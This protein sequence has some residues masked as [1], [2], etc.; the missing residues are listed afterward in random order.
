MDAP[1][2]V[3]TELQL[4]HRIQ[5]PPYARYLTAEENLR[6]SS[7]SGLASVELSVRTR[8]MMPDGSIQ[9]GADRHV[10]AAS[11]ANSSTDVLSPEAWLLGCEIQ[12]VVGTPRIGQVFVVLDVIRGS[13]SS[14]IVVD[15]I[16][17]GYVTDTTRLG[18]P[19]SI[20]RTSIDGPGVIRSITGTNPAAGNEILETVPT[21]ARWRLHAMNF[22]LTTSAT[23]ANRE[24]VLQIDDGVTAYV[25]IPSGNNQTASQVFKYTYARN[26]QRVL[27]ATA[28]A[29]VLPYPQI[30]MMGGH[31][32]GT[33]TTGLQA[34]DDYSAPQY[35]VE[36]WIE[37]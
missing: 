16:L 9:T 15:T 26:A 20:V 7:F 31:R 27:G 8:Y 22:T 18:F 2:P 14:A 25:A 21:N 24:P 23:V 32:F 29:I 5:P 30:D 4:Y 17:Q 3:E 6:V 37:D 35:L 34:G 11:R 28:L 33:L 10:P 19:G 36:E 12:A 1:D 13:G